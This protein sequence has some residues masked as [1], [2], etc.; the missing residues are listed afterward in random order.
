MAN[1]T[2]LIAEVALREA[3]EA[4]DSGLDKE[5]LFEA[6]QVKEEDLSAPVDG[7]TLLMQ[8]AQE[9]LL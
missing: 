8:L 1:K 5:V 7:A 9:G 6:V 2:T 4:D 3:I